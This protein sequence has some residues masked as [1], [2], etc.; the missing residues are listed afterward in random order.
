MRCV[1]VCVCVCVCMY[2]CMCVCVHSVP[3]GVGEIRT[4]NL[5]GRVE[6]GS[7]SRSLYLSLSY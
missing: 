2:V 1:C 6:S 3:W 5:Q 4:I 7:L